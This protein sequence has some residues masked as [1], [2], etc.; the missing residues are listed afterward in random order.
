MAEAN[1][2]RHSV[3]SGFVG[4]R[5]TLRSFRQHRSRFRLLV[6]TLINLGL[7]FG[8]MG[9]LF[10][11]ALRSRPRPISVPSQ[12][13]LAVIVLWVFAVWLVAK[14]VLLY[15]R[16]LDN[17]AFVLTTVSSRTAAVGLLLTEFL[18]ACVALAVPTPF[19]VGIIGYAFLEPVSLFLVPL[20]VVL[21]AATA[22]IGGYIV[23][24]GYLF[25]TVHFRSLAQH[26]SNLGIQ[27]VMVI[28]AG[29]IT[30]QVLFPVPAVTEVV[31]IEWLPISWFVDLAV[32]GTP[33]TV[34]MGRAVVSLLSSFIIIIG[35]GATAVRLATAHWATDRGITLQDRGEAPS[36]DQGR[37]TLAA[38][39][40]PYIIPSMVSPPTRRVA[41][42]VLLRLRR[43]PR[44]LTFLL[45]IIV[46]F[47]ISLGPAIV[48]MET[49]MA[50]ISVVC[51]VFVP[52]LTGAALG[53]N[54]LGDEGVVLPATL[55]ASV[56]GRE[57]VRGMMLP[58]LLYGLPVT[59]V[60]TLVPSVF[61]PY[62]LAEQIGLIILGAILIIV[63][64]VLAPAVGMRLPRF[65]GL[66]IGQS[67]EVVPPSLMAVTT[68]VFLAG[69]LSG[70]AI[71]LL[72]PP[73][74]V[75]GLFEVP[76]TG[77]G[78]FSPTMI[79]LGGFAGWLVILLG[80]SYWLYRDT[81]NRFAT[82]TVE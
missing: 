73:P 41:Q 63:A 7:F 31:A 20:A 57:F 27:L 39:I 10:A 43:A 64:V 38:A 4:F 79:R 49:P 59:V 75:Q 45:T 21:F 34:S 5:R 13:R 1:W 58:G 35:G 60:A 30:I 22:I 77:S 15:R 46:S 47:S 66:T 76:G 23:G 36:R 42:V 65:S 55:T 32:L 80:C 40:S 9:T 50:L 11:L 67:R 12:V 82:Y 53:L 69:G 71:L 24:F 17:E 25:L 61:S 26:Q 8:G 33:V 54:P 18:T 52:W 51:A 48:Q 62:T 37:D 68:Y 3:H 28:V 44:R 74:V 29:Y 6:F 56:S 14:R 78:L 81:A 70:I 19:L 2:V 16:R 72:F